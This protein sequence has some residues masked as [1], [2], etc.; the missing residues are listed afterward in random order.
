[1]RKRAIV[2]AAAA[3]ALLT[4]G[5]AAPAQAE[6]EWTHCHVLETTP[7]GEERLWYLYGEAH[8]AVSGQSHHWYKVGANL[9]SENVGLGNKNNLEFHL[10]ANQQAIWSHKSGDNVPANTWYEVNPDMFT[11]P[12]SEETVRMY[13][14][15]DRSW[16]AD[17]ECVAWTN[18]V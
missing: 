14:V 1:M 12:E 13:G 17:P 4:V 16:A 18:P 6:W 3:A 10:Y 8:Y 7:G 11:S 2:A 9:R 15:F 5:L